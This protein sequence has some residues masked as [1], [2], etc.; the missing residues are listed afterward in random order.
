MIVEER[1]TR[2]HTILRLV[3]ANDFTFEQ[4]AEKIR[5]LMSPAWGLTKQEFGRIIEHQVRCL[6]DE[7]RAVDTKIASLL[8]IR[9]K[10]LGP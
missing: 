1:I 7:R 10:V 8:H 5:G 6:Q 9:G 2:L 4:G 3:M